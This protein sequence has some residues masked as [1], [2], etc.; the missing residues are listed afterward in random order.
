MIRHGQSLYIES[1]GPDPATLKR[2][3]AWL[4][5]RCMEL[6]CNGIVAV[7]TKGSLE[8]FGW[9]EL[10]SL[11]L[12]LHKH[13]QCRVSGVTVQLF[14]SQKPF[15]K[16]HNSPIL[17]IHGDRDLLDKV[18][19]IPGTADVLF[20]PWNKEEQDEWAATRGATILGCDTAS[21]SAPLSG[22][23]Y[24][25]LLVLTEKTKRSGIGHSDDRSY[26]IRTLETLYRKGVVC[27]PRLIRQQLIRMGWFPKDA[28][29]VEQLAEQIWDGRRPDG[30][31]GEPDDEL[32]N[33]W[34]G[35][36]SHNNDQETG[37][38]G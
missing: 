38:E 30:S 29:L 14:T 21:D 24:T 12:A 23:A 18:D 32:W 20:I 5:R 15:A 9:S 16:L 25:A 36:Q 35:R 27:A 37:Q 1:I 19:S 22:V 13:G 8:S 4:T 26:A 2:G 6:N 11:F 17:V 33:Y 31:V 10:E 28:E 7:R 34:E 3:V